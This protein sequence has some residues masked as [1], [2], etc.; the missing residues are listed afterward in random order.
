ML[1]SGFM[2]ICLKELRR[3]VTSTSLLT[4][5]GVPQGSMLG[6]LLFAVYINVI[7]LTQTNDIIFYADDII[8][9]SH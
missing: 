6:L 5:K 9:Y 3:T 4:T 8:L 7:I 1:K 2:H